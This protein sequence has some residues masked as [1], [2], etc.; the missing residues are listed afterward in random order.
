MTMSKIKALFFDFDGVIL[1]SARIKTEAFGELFRRDHPEAVAAIVSYHLEHMGINRYKK[2]RHIYENILHLPIDVAL[3]DD[4]GRRFSEIVLEE[5]MRAPFLLGAKEALETFSEQYRMFIVSG[6]P[7]EELIHITE[8][9]GVGVFFD[10]VRGAPPGKPEIICELLKGSGILPN[11]SIF[12]GDALS[13]QRAAEET[14]LHFIAVQG[15]E[16]DRLS[17]NQYKVKDL[18]EIA[19]MIRDIEQ[20]NLEADDRV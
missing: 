13:D 7:E 11:E 10:E 15:G 4:L 2:F 8:Q 14:G 20:G 6:T 18:R 12:I 17:N 5:V 19:Q 9:R 1:D 16:D 3:E